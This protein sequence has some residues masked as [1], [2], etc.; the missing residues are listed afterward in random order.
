MKLKISKTKQEVAVDFARYLAILIAARDKVHI[1]LSGGSTPTVVFDEL[2]ANFQP[3]IDWT[4]VQLY[5][6]DE[7]CVPPTHEESNF[8]MTV[9]HLISKIDIP[10]ENIH[11]INGENTPE[12]EAKR[13][14][15]LLD[16][17]LPTE[18]GLPRF[19][20]VILGLGDD[21]HTAS[22]F[23][24]QIQLWESR[25]NCEVAVHPE[26]GQKRIT[27]TGRIINNANIVTFLVTGENKARKVK[28][29]INGVGEFTNYPASLVRPTSGKLLW[30][31]DVAAA[32][33]LT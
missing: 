27:I 13:Y 24:H 15:Q 23:P 28:E 2:A 18:N 9:D 12:H 1:A 21:G 14:G 32:G 11:P 33:L 31:L 10:A 5:W 7:R 6:G 25:K 3:D 22:I 17:S 26:S 8:K 29:I 30:F 16:S 19:D 4:K 20:L